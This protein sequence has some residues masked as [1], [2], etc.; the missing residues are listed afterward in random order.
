MRCVLGTS[1]CKIMAW[2]NDVQESGPVGSAPVF[3]GWHMELSIRKAASLLGVSEKTIYRWIEERRIPAYRVNESTGS[4]RPNCWSGPTR[5]PVHPPQSLIEGAE[6]APPSFT[7]EAALQ[8]G[9]VHPGVGGRDGASV[10]QAVVAAMPLPGGRRPGVP[11]AGA[12]GARERRVDRHRRRDRHPARAQPH[13]HAHAP[14]DRLPV[15]PEQPIEFGAI[16]GKPVH[17]LFTI[18]SP[19]IK[20]HLR[21]CRAW[22]SRC[23]TRRSPRSIARKGALAEILPHARRIDGMVAGG[24]RDKAVPA[25]MTLLP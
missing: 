2:V 21:S 14:P 16:D 15:L 23:G 9:G 8:A 12:A 7:L 24:T 17:T 13:R 10:L 25:V 1:H 22:R 11:A 6:D 5:N 3:K 20:A 18:V 19:T 4:T